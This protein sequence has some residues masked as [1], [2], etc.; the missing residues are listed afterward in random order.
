MTTKEQDIETICREILSLGDE[1]DELYK[2]AKQVRKQAEEANDRK[3]K[4]LEALAALLGDEYDR[5]AFQTLN[6][7]DGRLII[8][9]VEK[10]KHYIPL[11]ERLET[12]PG[13]G[14]NP[15]DLTAK[16]APR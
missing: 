2:R 11:V 6:P 1:R 15:R 12:L 13:L 5:R 9:V 3:D 10:T 8:V 4:A 16:E 7:T 14:A